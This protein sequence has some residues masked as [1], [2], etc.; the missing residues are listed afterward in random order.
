M[1]SP[2]GGHL[3]QHAQPVV[4]PPDGRVS[5]GGHLSE[6]AQPVVPPPDVRVPAGGYSSQ[7]ARPI[8]TALRRC[9]PEGWRTAR[10][11]PG[12]SGATALA[13]VAAGAAVVAAVGVWSERPRAE[14]VNV[15][16]AVAVVAD[17][18]AGPPSA[19]PAPSGPLV[20]SV[21]GKV[22]NPGLVEV[23]DGARVADVVAAAGGPLPGADLTAVNLARHVSDGEQIAIGVP[24]AL[25]AGGDQSATGSSGGSASGDAP[26]G[27]APGGR[28]NLNR[29][30]AQQLDALPGVGPVTAERILEWRN[31]NGR[32]ARVD[33]LREVEGI[34]ERRFGQLRELV[35]V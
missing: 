5:A 10:V 22:H 1:Q 13:L 4:T 23:P 11:D 8:A 2:A 17:A 25:D 29:A 32:F 27:G 24:P 26:S 31:H 12:R 3:S 9:L 18:P 19:E 28:V 20:V 6:R 16:P 14:P 21:T 30:T 7:R 33:Q 35:T 15:L 34:G